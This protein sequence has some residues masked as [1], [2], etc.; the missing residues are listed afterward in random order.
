MVMGGTIIEPPLAPTWPMVHLASMTPEY[1]VRVTGA[2]LCRGIVE[3]IAAAMMP[4]AK[5]TVY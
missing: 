1:A 3:A 4:F 2:A 5:A